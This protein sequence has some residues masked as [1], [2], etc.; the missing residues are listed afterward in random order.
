[1]GDEIE[2]ALDTAFA[3]IIQGWPQPTDSQ[4]PRF[5][6][7]QESRILDS[8]IPY[9]IS[10]TTNYL[11]DLYSKLSKRPITEKERSVF[12]EISH[13]DA[14]NIELGILLARANADSEH[15][16]IN[17]F[18][19]CHKFIEQA[20]GSAMSE[21]EKREYVQNLKERFKVV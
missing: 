4:I 12:E 3:S 17:G 6:D 13:H 19:Y 5:P 2:R 20:A 8:Q 16:R 14:L 21:V 15:Q 10:S 7:S 11:L 1:M 18:R 9:S